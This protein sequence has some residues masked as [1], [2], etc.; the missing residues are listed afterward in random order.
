MSSVDIGAGLNDLHDGRS[1]FPSNPFHCLSR[2]VTGVLAPTGASKARA[3]RG[4]DRAEPGRRRRLDHAELG[5]VVKSF[6][7]GPHSVERH[8]ERRAG[9]HRGE[10]GSRA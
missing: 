7:C 1:S 10:Q 3:E 4:A 2:T 5:R 6:H 8:S 9:A